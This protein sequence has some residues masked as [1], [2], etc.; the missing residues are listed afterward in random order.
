[1]IAH[2]R[3]LHGDVSQRLKALEAER[4][5]FL[6]KADRS[7]LFGEM[8]RQEIRTWLRSLSDGERMRAAM[9]DDIIREAVAL[10]P[11]A[12]SGLDAE[13]H[14]HVVNALVE[15]RHGERVAKI[16][17]ESEV[18]Q[19]ADVAIREAANDLHKASGAEIELAA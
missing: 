7:D 11:A 15:A 1:M 12:L 13:R 19:T 4:A 17:Y 3:Q 18:L 10:A 6:P 16:V 2:L 5:S 9:S 8:Q 14:G